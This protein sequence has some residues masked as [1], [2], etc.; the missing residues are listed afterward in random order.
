ME[1][2]ISTINSIMEKYYVTG[3]IKDHNELNNSF[4]IEKNKNKNIALNKEKKNDIFQ[5]TIKKLKQNE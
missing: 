4:F 1:K 3:E 2:S 5:N